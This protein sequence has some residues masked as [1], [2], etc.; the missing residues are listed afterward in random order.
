MSF[1]RTA[2]NDE[3]DVVMYGERGLRAFEITRSAVFRETDLRGLRLFCADYP[4]ARGYLLYG[5]TRRYQ[6]DRIEVM[7]FDEAI[8]TLGALLT[9]G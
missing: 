5:G 6:F 7:P 8:R 3:V 4:G 9:D 2:A 1:W